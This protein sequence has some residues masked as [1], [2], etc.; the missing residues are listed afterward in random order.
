MEDAPL[1]QPLVVAST[2]TRPPTTA[3]QAARLRARDSLADWPGPSQASH[4]HRAPRIGMEACLGDFTYFSGAMGKLSTNCLYHWPAERLALRYAREERL[5]ETCTIGALTDAVA[6][7]AAALQDLGIG[8][9]DRVAVYAS[10]VAGSFVAIYARHRI[11]AVYCVLRHRRTPAVAHIKLMPGG[12]AGK[13][14]QTNRRYPRTAQTV[15]KS[16]RTGRVDALFA[17]AQNSKGNE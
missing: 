4:W 1:N 8:K 17:H 2:R 11:G 6:C 7:I 5:K 9:G 3:A 10:N 15:P 12:R 14:S 13:H 16:A